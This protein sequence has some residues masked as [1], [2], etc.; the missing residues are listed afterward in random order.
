MIDFL[1]R[2]P[3]IRLLLPLVTGIVVCQLVVMSD[4]MLMGLSAM[5][6]CL[7]GY[8]F[9]IKDINFQ[10][11]FRWL[12]G[13]GI[14]L[15]LFAMGCYL[16]DKQNH[17]NQFTALNEKG[18]FKVEL[19]ASPIEK[20]KTYLCKVQVKGLY[21][22]HHWQSQSG[23]AIVYIQKDSAVTR[24]LYGDQLMIG[25]TFKPLQKPL[26]P[27]EFDYATYLQRQGIGATCYLPSGTWTVMGHDSAFSVFRMADMCRLNLLEVYKRFNISGDEYAVIAALT[28]GY[29]DALQPELRAGY[30]ATGAMHILSVSG[31]HVGVIYAVLLFLLGWMGKTERGRIIRALLILC[32]LWIYAFI[33]GLSAA[34]VRSSLMF[35]FV[36]IGTCINRKSLIYNTIFISMFITLLINPFLLFDVGFQLSYAAV[37]S[38]IFFHPMLAKIYSPKSKLGKFCWEM[39]SVSI[40]AQLATTPFTLYYFQQFPNYF[41]LTNLIAIPL[42]TLAIY[43]A[44]GLFVFSYIP[45]ISSLVA[46]L[47]KWCTWCMNESII[48]IQH[49]P[50]SLSVVSLT[51]IQTCLLFGAIMLFSTYYFNRKFAPLFLGLLLLLC[52]VGLDITQTYSTMTSNHLIVYAGQRHTHINLIN[53]KNNKVITTDSVE[54]SK[55]ANNY[56]RKHKLEMPTYYCPT[57]IHA[58]SF[59]KKTIVV[60][61]SLLL[62]KRTLKAPLHVDYLIIGNRMKPRID[63]V[64]ENILP[65]TIIID[66]NI[67]KWYAN[68]VINR[69]KERGIATYSISDHGA[70]ILTS[71][72]QQ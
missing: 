62:T 63:K 2:T 5:G 14:F 26:N 71:Y 16:V 48:F 72:S 27:D 43:L 46:F 38:I 53:H 61:D 45:Y 57:Q 49:L 64:L 1:H 31:L 20:S 23:K 65:K 10:Y 59:G 60:L 28:L 56:W 37:L 55:I 11:K 51:L 7:C 34:V 69:C 32:F 40:A 66:R 41:L 13:C 19:I 33:T 30:S 54:A 42:S 58:M 44:I 21:K 9:F 39:V 70:F 18:I 67:S 12:F 15:F 17:K 29:T 36:V 24:L 50:F 47:L 8:S 25:T 4:W 22:N 52:V 3:F 6:V 35:S 68:D